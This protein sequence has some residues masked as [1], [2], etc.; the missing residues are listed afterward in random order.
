M[1]RLFA[2]A[3][4]AATLSGCT[5]SAEPAPPSPSPVAPAALAGGACQL[6]DFGV[7]ERLLG[8]HYTVAAA[9]GK[10]TTLTCVA[11][12]AGA[13]YP[14]V[15]LSVAPS[16]ADAAVFRAKVQ[17]KGATVVDGLGKAAYRVE[18]PGVEGQGPAQEIGWLASNARLLWLRVTLPVGKQ[19][20]DLGLPL[21][22]LAQEIDKLKPV[23]LS[24]SPSPSR[25]VAS[26][27]ATTG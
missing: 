23:V 24:P 4:A 2:A 9:A 15:T 5:A 18:L 6:L 17:P 20:A 13:A 10:D 21:V 22:V 8:E 3:V 14:E 7:L 25:A 27:S 12:T 26:P 11:R 19:A 1:R 16:I